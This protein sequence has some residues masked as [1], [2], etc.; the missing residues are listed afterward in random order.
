M[1]KILLLLILVAATASASSL[2]EIRDILKH[3]ETDYNPRAIGDGGDSFGI[4]QIQQGAIDDVNRKYGTDYTHQDAFDIVCAE[5]IFELYIQMWTEKLEE[6]EKRPATEEDIVRIWNGGPRGWKRQGTLK[7]LKK[8]RIYKTKHNMNQR[9]VLVNGKLGVITATYT[10]TCD[11]FMFQTR[12]TLV[13]VSRR[14]TKLLPKEVKAPDI[15][16]KMAL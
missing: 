13:G 14:V 9:K 11:V 2:T 4:L 1:R 16:Y 15:Q 5:E 3:V 7:Y 10:H 6:R 8:Y 12:K